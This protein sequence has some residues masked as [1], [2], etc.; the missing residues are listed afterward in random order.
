MLKDLRVFLNTLS[1][2]MEL[3]RKGG[4][5]SHMEQ[6]ETENE[7]ILTVRISKDP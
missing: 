3:L 1:R 2:G 7:L 4:I 6:R 5:N